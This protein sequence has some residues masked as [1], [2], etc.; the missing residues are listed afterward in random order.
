MARENLDVKDENVFSDISQAW[1]MNDKEWKIYSS[2][3]WNTFKI[4]KSPSW[5]QKI[6]TFFSISENFV[7]DGGN[8]HSSKMLP[9]P[10]IGALQTFG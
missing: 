9:L 3:Q 7:E 8:R 4:M 2:I 6:E 1:T 10:C 5:V